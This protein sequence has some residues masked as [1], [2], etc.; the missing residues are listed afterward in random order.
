[1]MMAVC[2]LP[3]PVA[4]QASV[5]FE[6]RRLDLEVLDSLVLD[7]MSD[8][9]LDISGLSAR[10]ALSSMASLAGDVDAVE[11]AVAVHGWLRSEGDA[12]LRVNFRSLSD[13]TTSAPPPDVPSLLAPEGPWSRFGPGPGVPESAREAWLKRTWPWIC[14][15]GGG[16]DL[17]HSIPTHEKGPEFQE[18]DIMTVR[19]ERGFVHWVIRGFGLGSEKAFRRDFR[20][21]LR[22]VKRSGLPVLL[23]LRGNSG[24]FRT[25]RHAVLAAFVKESEWPVEQEGAWRRTDDVFIEVPPMPSTKC[26]RPIEA[27]LAVM[28]DG[29]SFSASLLLV[30]AL[31]HAGRARLFG[32]APLGWPGG[33]SGNPEQHRLPGS[34]L[35]VEVPT[36]RTVL[37]LDGVEPYG[38]PDGGDLTGE[39]ERGQWQEAVDWLLSS[40]GAS[41]Q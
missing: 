25:R 11:W 1:M 5:S 33:C 35:I 37:L 41:P 36:R 2:C 27:P 10:D 22:Q 8:G 12:H 38:L 30:D 23:D 21:A 4:G 16:L 17:G 19:E 13:A 29:L 24:G 14:P 31:L 20:V 9:P 39:V 34:G 40:T 6:E 15:L 7:V 26:R 28:V 18:A 32:R 3:L